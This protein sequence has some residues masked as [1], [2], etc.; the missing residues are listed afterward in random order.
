MEIKVLGFCCAKCKNTY[1][2]IEKVIK[3]NGLDVKLAKVTDME[4]I[5]EYNVMTVPAVVVDGEVKIKGRVPT[6]GEIK[7]MLG[8]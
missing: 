7:E 4:E 8:V 3:E 1:Q 5:M 6:E 2:L